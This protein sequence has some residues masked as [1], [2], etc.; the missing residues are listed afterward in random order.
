MIDLSGFPPFL[1]SH[2]WAAT[3]I[4]L[5]TELRQPFRSTCPRLTISL[6]RTATNS[7]HNS[8]SR[9]TSLREPPTKIRMIAILLDANGYFFTDPGHSALETHG[10]YKP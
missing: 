9:G 10:S 4:S 2:S 8:G 7:R 3:A 5:S 6:P 1:T